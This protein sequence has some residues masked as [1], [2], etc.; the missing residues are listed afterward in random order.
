MRH[1]FTPIRGKVN[2]ESY[3]DIGSILKGLENQE[4]L[5]RH[6]DENSLTTI[7][8]L[9]KRNVKSIG[10]LFNDETLDQTLIDANDKNI[11]V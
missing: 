6:Y 11:A 3:D 7:D 1:N 8:F 2:D 10:K 5:G 9:N 4:R